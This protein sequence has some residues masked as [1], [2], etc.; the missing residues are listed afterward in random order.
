MKAPSEARTKRTRWG[1]RGWGTLSAAQQD[2]AL[3]MMRSG[4]SQQATADQIGVTK[5]VIAGIW[6]RWGDPVR[7]PEFGPSTLFERCDAL[8]AQMDAVL[9]E[10]LGV[11]RIVLPPVIKQARR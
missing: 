10:T 8:H 7:M 5:N 2:Q 9:A 1:P 6:K 3:T 11:G 4:M